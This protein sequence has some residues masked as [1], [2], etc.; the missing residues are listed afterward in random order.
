MEGKLFSLVDGQTFLQWLVIFFLVLLFVYKEWPGFWERV[1][2]KAQGEQMGTSLS[3]RLDRIESD[4]QEV[5]S[6]LGRDYDRLNAVERKQVSDEHMIKEIKAEQGIIMRALLGA[7]GGLQ[8]LGA[9]G[10]TEKAREEIVDWLNEQAHD[11]GD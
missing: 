9:N 6:R 4:I 8:E 3:S 11:G 1:K 10:S 5:M 2:K 7:L